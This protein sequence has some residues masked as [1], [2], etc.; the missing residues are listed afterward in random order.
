MK[1]TEGV[2]KNI[3]LRLL[4][5]KTI[6]EASCEERHKWLSGHRIVKVQ[7]PIFASDIFQCDQK[8]EVGLAV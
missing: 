7:V 1:R 2:E 3:V 5:I 4:T 6:Q 8:W